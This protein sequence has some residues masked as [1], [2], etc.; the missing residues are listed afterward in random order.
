[1]DRFKARKLT[2]VHH[3]VF[4]QISSVIIGNTDFLLFITEILD[5]LVTSHYQN[6]LPILKYFCLLLKELD[7]LSYC[8][9]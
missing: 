1:M 3:I 8:P 9:L 2:S 6:C 5:C 7:P 4:R